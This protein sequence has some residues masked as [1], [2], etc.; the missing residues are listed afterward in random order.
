MFYREPQWITPALL[1][2]F[3]QLAAIDPD[4][5]PR[6][7]G[8]IQTVGRVYPTVP[9]VACFDTAFHRHMP[10]VAQ[11]YALPGDYAD[12]GL[13][14]YGFHGLSYEYIIGALRAEDRAV[15]DGRVIIAHLGNGASMAAV[16]GGIGIDTTMGF[17]PTGN[18]YG[19]GNTSSVRCCC[20]PPPFRCTER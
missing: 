13:T 2:A 1:T 5:L 17:T 14:R 11:R 3:G 8:A 18:G 7:L 20:S 4:H 10:P 12:A 19:F 15:A 9:Q 16:Q 6:T